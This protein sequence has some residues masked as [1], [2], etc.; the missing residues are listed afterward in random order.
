[1]ATLSDRLPLNVPGKFYVDT[2][3]IDC[4]QCRTAAPQ[5][6]ARDEAAGMSYVHAQPSTPEECAH[7]E[8][9]IEDC[10]SSSIGNDGEGV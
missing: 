6:F 4:D 5:F 1:M 7:L 2:S 8:Q 9:I 10:A 3:C